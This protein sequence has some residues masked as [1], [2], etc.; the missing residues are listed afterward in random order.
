MQVLGCLLGFF[1]V[2]LFIFVAL[3]RGAWHLLLGKTAFKHMGFGFNPDASRDK[4]KGQ[5][6]N[7]SSTSAKQRNKVID[8][9]EGEY[10][11][12]EEIKN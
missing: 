12:F 5:T 8:D 11:D 2:L 3:V 9:N 6:H 1:I 10:V 7:A 4:A